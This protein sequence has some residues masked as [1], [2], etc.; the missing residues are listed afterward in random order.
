MAKMLAIYADKCTGYRSYELACSKS[1]EGSFRLATTR[2]IEIEDFR[3][4]PERDRE[5]YYQTFWVPFTDDMPVMQGLQYI[6]DHL[7]GSFTFCW[8]APSSA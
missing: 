4:N 2:T 5:S 7:D 3:Y 6:K 8:S 1:H